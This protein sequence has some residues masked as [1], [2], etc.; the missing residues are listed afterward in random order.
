MGGEILKN[1]QSGASLLSSNKECVMEG[2]KEYTMDMEIEEQK[3]N[4][5]VINEKEKNTQKAT[6]VDQFSSAISSI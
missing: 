3:N 4:N 2:T 6:D 1:L 5:T